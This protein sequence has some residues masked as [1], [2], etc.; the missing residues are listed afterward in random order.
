MAQVYSVAITVV[1]FQT[2]DVNL[3]ESVNDQIPPTS[4]PLQQRGHIIMLS[5]VFI[6]HVA[7]NT[8]VG[9]HCYRQTFRAES[10]VRK[11]LVA[12]IGA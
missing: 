6:S 1:S 9:D 3:S 11:Q 4:P 8:D 5:L 2:Y 7:L 10:S 12:V